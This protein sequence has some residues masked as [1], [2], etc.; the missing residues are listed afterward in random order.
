VLDLQ[1]IQ[2]DVSDA[3]VQ[4]EFDYLLKAWCLPYAPVRSF[5]KIKSGF[6]KWFATLGFGSNDW[7]DIQRVVACSAVNQRIFS[8]VIEVAKEQY[9]LQ[10]PEHLAGRKDIT[11]SIYKVPAVVMSGDKHEKVKLEKYAYSPAYLL[12]KRSSP[13]KAL[14]EAL[15]SS[16]RIE[17]WLK[18]GEG[19]QQ[20]FSLVYDY[21]D[22]ETG[23][24]KKANFFPD[25]IVKFLDGS[26]GL[27]E[28]KSGI[29]L[30]DYLTHAKS[31]ALQAYIIQNSAL[32]LQ[33]GIVNYTATGLFVFT[34]GKYTPDKSEWDALKL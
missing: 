12:G 8:E 23:L 32:K 19:Q 2:A 14:E 6:Y 10:K 31:D 20:F 18:N 3:N 27:Y 17:W 25:F 13:E 4:R 22:A 5:T 1:K 21:V 26:I 7:N 16:D 15:E 30:T 9:E 34:K 24:G 11:K 33:G 28:T 29:T